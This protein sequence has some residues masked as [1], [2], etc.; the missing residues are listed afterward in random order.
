MPA[1]PGI[2]D[3]L[4]Q[5]VGTAPMLQRR[6]VRQR[7]S[8]LSARQRLS[9]ALR[10]DRLSP[11]RLWECE[12]MDRVSLIR[13]G[14]PSVLV[15]RLASEMR[16]SVA[17]ASRLAGLAP[18]TVLRKLAKQARLNTYQG[19]RVLGLARLIG[20]VHAETCKAGQRRG[21]HAGRWVAQWLNSPLPSLSGWRPR[22]LMD[23]DVGRELIF[24]AIARMVADGRLP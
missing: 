19:E 5:S 6:R 21:F 20:Q 2:D 18:T 16:L 14:V 3:D 7:H 1:F 10:G 15:K 24:A 8:P 13:D 17:E 23:L 22:D 4:E 12:P 9:S 11:V